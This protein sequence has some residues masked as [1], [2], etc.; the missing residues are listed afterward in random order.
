MESF[1]STMKREELYGTLYHSLNELKE[2]VD[3]FINRYNNERPHVTLNYKAPMR[4]NPRFSVI[5]TNNKTGQKCSKVAFLVLK[6]QNF[7][8]FSR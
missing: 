4:M 5:R 6:P 1:F 8:V 2:R 7:I 3:R